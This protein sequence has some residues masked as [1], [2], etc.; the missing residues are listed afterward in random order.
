MEKAEKVAVIDMGTNTFNLLVA[1][2]DGNGITELYSNKIP[3]KLGQGGFENKIIT[4][5]AF[6]RAALA[7]DNFLSNTIE[8]GCEKIMA[9]ATSAVRSSKN[10]KAFTEFIYDR[11]ELEIEIL[12]GQKE[13]EFIYKG[14]RLSN[15]LG[16]QNDLIMDIGGGSTEF[17]IGNKNEVAESFSFDLGAAR[18]L[19]YFNPSDP[20]KEDDIVK[21]NKHI[22]TQLS[23][24][25]DS[26]GKF[27]PKRL[28]GSSGSFD[29]IVDMV[30]QELGSSTKKFNQIQ[31]NDFNRIY[32]IIV[33]SK[34]EER[35]DIQGLISM[36]IDFIV[37]SIILMKYIISTYKFTEIYQC[38]YSLKEGLIAH[39]INPS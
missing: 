24:L 13:A 5:Q 7:I 20:I 38:G 21:I 11:Y 3:V 8:F 2:L 1:Q 36:R 6:D 4:Q 23:P 10:G 26:I 17:I 22:E 27:Q 18:I 29:S 37:V 9:V 16:E 35:F 19:E 28:I 12:T 33:K 30:A 39:S 14:V 25:F 32:D 15:L 34:R 31:L